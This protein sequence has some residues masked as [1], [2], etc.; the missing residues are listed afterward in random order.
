MLAISIHTPLA[1][2]DQAPRRLDRQAQI[3]I[4]TPLAGSDLA[5]IPA[6][7]PDRVF[8]STL[9]L[10]GATCF[11]WLTLSL[12]FISIHTPLAGS[13]LYDCTWPRISFISIHTPLAG[14][15]FSPAHSA[16]SPSRFQ[17]TLPLRGATGRVA[18][19][20]CLEY[21]NPHSPCGERRIWVTCMAVVVVFQST[22]PLRGA[23]MSRLGDNLVE[24]FQSTLPL[25]GAT[26]EMRHF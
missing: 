6:M 25:R 10:R 22:L 9:P 11:G 21:F 16:S 15:D 8:Q 24:A 2:S 18:L 13:D 3:S 12:I 19:R 26:A 7:A 5:R 23:T 4:H 1:G 20:F 14:S 17:S